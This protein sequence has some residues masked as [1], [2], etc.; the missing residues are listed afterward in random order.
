MKS[1]KNKQKGSGHKRKSKRKTLLD[2]KS[3]SFKN[4]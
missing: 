3:K 4:K 1:F 2:K